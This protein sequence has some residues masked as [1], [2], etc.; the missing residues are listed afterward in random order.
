MEPHETAAEAEA[1]TRLG[2]ANHKLKARSWN[3]METVR[4][5]KEAVGGDYT[6]GVDPNTEFRL[7]HV[8]ARLAAELELFG[9][10][11]VFE[12]PVLKHNLD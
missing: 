6:V 7:P 12:D 9:T 5:M 8:A 11:S 10:V 1:G 3:I 2:F 4:L